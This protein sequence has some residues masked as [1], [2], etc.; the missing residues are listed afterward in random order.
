MTSVGYEAEMAGQA[1]ATADSAGDSS[2]QDNLTKYEI[3]ALAAELGVSDGHPRQEPT[4]AQ[5]KILAAMPDLFE[6]AEAEPFEALEQ[7]AQRAFLSSTGQYSA[8]V[9]A[10]RVLSCYSSSVV[11]DVLARTLVARH[12]RVGL[13]HPTFDNIPDLLKRWGLKLVPLD[14]RSVCTG[15]IPVAVAELDAL[16][17]TTPNNPTGTYLSEEALTEIAEQCAA[18][19]VLLVLDVCFRGFEPAFQ[20]DSYELLDTTGVDYVLIEDTGKLWPM[21]ELKLGFAAVSENCTVALA[22]AMSDVLLSVSPFVLALVTELSHQAADG[23]YADLHKLVASNRSTL[24]H[25][26][27]GTPARVVDERSR[28]SVARVELP[29]EM[30]ATGAYERLRKRGVHILPC[31][32]FHWADNA[33]GERYIRVALG[34]DTELVH[35]TASRMRDFFGEV[36]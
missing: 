5:H 31:G 36:A 19:D 28:I 32:P 34:R 20:Y 1:A 27:A 7:S 10:G 6:R 13:I 24:T 14:E 22:D 21:S 3:T 11:T 29:A 33:E 25:A 8:P 4:P 30:T 23:G 16:F 35:A 15:R 17:I 2:D 18:A 9:G 12:P 26:L